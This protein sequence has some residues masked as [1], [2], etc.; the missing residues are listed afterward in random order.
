MRWLHF[1]R[2]LARLA[3]WLWVCSAAL[4][5]RTSGTPYYLINEET[6]TRARRIVCTSSKTISLKEISILFFSTVL[7]LEH[8][9][10]CLDKSEPR[11]LLHRALPHRAQST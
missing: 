10:Q 1:A 9:F 7:P 11:L 5:T 3:A 4:L 2:R 6:G 8:F